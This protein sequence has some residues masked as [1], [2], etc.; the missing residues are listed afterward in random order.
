MTDTTD[1]KA[2]LERAAAY[3]DSRAEPLERLALA[4][5][6]SRDDGIVGA[7]QLCRADAAALRA[8]AATLDEPPWL[9]A[10][11]ECGRV[12]KVLETIT[13]DGQVTPSLVMVAHS[14]DGVGVLSE[15]VVDGKVGALVR[16]WEISSEDAANIAPAAAAAALR[17]LAATM[18][19]PAWLD[20]PDGPETRGVVYEWLG[21][22]E[23][24][25]AEPV[26]VYRNGLDAFASTPHDGCLATLRKFVRARPGWRYQRRV[27]VVVPPR[28]VGP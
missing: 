12:P 14:C 21:G 28:D 8:L 13:S 4:L 11:E 15:W 22:P 24:G 18:D 1:T 5:D 6:V 27:P 7:A 23:N 10:C 17:A 2:L 25:V 19:E 20:A 9:P 26:E 3:S 16:A